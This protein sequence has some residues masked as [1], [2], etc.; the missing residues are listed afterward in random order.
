MKST[1][2]L[3]LI[4]VLIPVFLAGCTFDEGNPDLSGSWTCTETSEIYQPVLKGQS[5]YQVTLTRDLVNQNKY[6]VENFYKLGTD[7]QVVI[8]KDGYTITIPKQTVNGFLFEGAGAVNETFDLMN[9]TYTAD[10]GGGEVDHVTAEY[11]R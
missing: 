5:I 8:L 10:D 1:D 4:L 11:G 2:R 7:I 9:L 3:R 6:Y